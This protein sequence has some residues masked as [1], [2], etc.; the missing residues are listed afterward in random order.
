MANQS[1][2]GN[3]AGSSSR[4][5]S[6]SAAEPYLFALA[7]LNLPIRRFPLSSPSKKVRM[8]EQPMGFVE[9]ARHLG[10]QPV[11]FRF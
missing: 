3:G 10:C 9:I 11:E 7:P 8:A 5:V 4:A 6:A 1:R 2:D